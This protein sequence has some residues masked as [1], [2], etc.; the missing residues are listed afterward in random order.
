MEIPTFITHYS[1]SEPFRSITS[2]SEDNWENVIRELTE[3][4]AWGLS[5]FKDPEYLN[6]RKQVEIRMRQEFVRMG[7]APEISNP[8]Y[9]FLGRSK[10]FEER[11]FNIGYMVSL[12]NISSEKITFTY[13]DSLL[14]WD[15]DYKSQSGPKYQNSLCSKLFR[16]EALTNLFC[17]KDFP[18]ESPLHIEAQLWMNPSAKTVKRLD[19]RV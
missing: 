1:R 11:E 13:G 9:F 10:S 8:I 15:E 6:R 4:T 17:H 19:G 3:E 7:G 16:M 18:K 5:R 14:A 12:S 2:L